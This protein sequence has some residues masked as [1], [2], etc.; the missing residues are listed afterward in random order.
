MTQARPSVETLVPLA[1]RSDEELMARWVESRRAGR[2]DEAAFETLYRR[3]RSA[4]YGRVSAVLGTHAA[5]ADDLV[6][7]TWT[8]VALAEAWTPR[9]FRAWVQTIA[10]RKALDRIARS[11]VRTAASDEPRRDE[12]GGAGPTLLERIPS[13]DAGP[14]HDA[15][16][17][18][19][20]RVVLQIVAGLP[21]AQRDAWIL[22]FVEGA[23]F[24]E[25]AAQQQVPLG[26]AKT[27]VRL[28]VEALGEALEQSGLSSLREA[29]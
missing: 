13:G 20:A 16:T 3:H 12:G 2:P 10:T 21:D 6:Q 27:R 14:E 4:T 17:R 9:S 1:K 18:G 8:E 22:R 5:H 26:T 7:E 19:I 15:H 23:Q 24:D 29:S 25:I 11:D 28:A